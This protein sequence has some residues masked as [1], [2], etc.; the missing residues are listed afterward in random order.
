[1]TRRTA[2]KP[3]LRVPKTG[4]AKARHLPRGSARTSVAA[5]EDEC[6]TAITPATAEWNIVRGD[7]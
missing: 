3:V 4:W 1:M 5:V 6:A 2:E 7:D